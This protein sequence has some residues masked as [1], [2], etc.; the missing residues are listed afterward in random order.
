MSEY[1]PDAWV[2]IELKDPDTRLPF[3]KVLAG[4]IG[5]Y[6]HGDS[7]RL[8]SGVTKIVP[9]NNGYAI[10][11]E[12]GS[13]Y[14]VGTPNERFTSLTWSIYQKICERDPQMSVKQIPIASV[15]V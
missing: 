8:S 1:T 15:V 5:G 12:S 3:R 9:N 10:H 2:L 4:W 7:W 13:I 11:N 14:H 6:L